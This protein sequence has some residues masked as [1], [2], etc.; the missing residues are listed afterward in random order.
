MAGSECGAIM[1]SAGEASGDVRGA[2]LCL[3][4]IDG[5]QVARAS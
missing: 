3:A 1:L 4:L 5:L 2:T